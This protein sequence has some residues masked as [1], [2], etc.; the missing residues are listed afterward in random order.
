MTTLPSDA[1]TTLQE[2]REVV[3]TFVAE[4]DWHRFHAPKNISMALAVEA[5][6]LMEHFEWLDVDASRAVRDDKTARDA[7]GEELCDVVCYAL[8]MAN[9]LDL[10][11]ASAFHAKMQ[12]NRKKY[13]A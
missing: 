13:P 5:A 10:D 3:E 11:I 6:E 4:R 12:K 2:L 7:A 8:A 1:T 9:A